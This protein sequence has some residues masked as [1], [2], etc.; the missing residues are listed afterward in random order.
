LPVK[1]T[2]KLVDWIVEGG[3]SP[4]YGARNLKRFIRQNVTLKLADVILQG[5]KYSE[6]AP[7]IR[8]GELNLVGIDE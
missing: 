2:K 5:P 3:Y 6:Y 8:D 7:K 4:E 1:A